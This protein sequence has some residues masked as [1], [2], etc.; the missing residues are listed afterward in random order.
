MVGNAHS[1]DGGID[2]G[3]VVD[4]P[5]AQVVSVDEECSLGPVALWSG[6]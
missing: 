6:T 3:R 2:G 1:D 5:L 4:L